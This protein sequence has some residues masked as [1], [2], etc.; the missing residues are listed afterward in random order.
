MIYTKEVKFTIPLIPRTKKNSGQIFVNQRTGRPFIAPSAVYKEYEKACWV[1]LKQMDIQCPVNVK[2]IFYMPTR[3][4]VDLCNLLSA[5]CDILVKYKVIVDDNSNIVVS[6]DG[7][8]VKYDKKLPR[9]EITI[10]P[11]KEER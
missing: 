1:Y 2:C 6:H 5:I 7:S 3:R 4:R 10:T 9:T 11:I 8:R